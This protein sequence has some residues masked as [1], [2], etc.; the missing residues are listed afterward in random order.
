MLIVTLLTYGAFKTVVELTDT[1]IESTTMMVV[2]VNT[3]LKIKKSDLTLF[4]NFS[5]IILTLSLCQ[6]Y[7]NSA[8]VISKLKK[9]KRILSAFVYVLNRI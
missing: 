3:S 5:I 9:R 1:A 7:V 6:V 4:E 8:G 2:V